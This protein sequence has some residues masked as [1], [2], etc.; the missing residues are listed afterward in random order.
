MKDPI[1]QCEVD[2]IFF[3]L[4]IKNVIFIKLWIKQKEFLK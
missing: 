2:L 4:K 1:H 3:K